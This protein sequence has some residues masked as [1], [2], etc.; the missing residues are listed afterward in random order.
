MNLFAGCFFLG[1][2]WNGDDDN[3]KRKK[4]K[5]E[6]EKEEKNGEEITVSVVEY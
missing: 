5:K 6:G 3:T 4:K 1:L 2:M